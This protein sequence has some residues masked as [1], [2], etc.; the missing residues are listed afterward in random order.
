MERVTGFLLEELRED[1]KNE[2]GGGEGWSTNV[3]GSHRKT[4]GEGVSR[5]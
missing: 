1:E 4:T 5:L 3:V 2:E